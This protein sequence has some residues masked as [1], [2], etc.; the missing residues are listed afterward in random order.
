MYQPIYQSPGRWGF[1]GGQLG[2]GFARG[3]RGLKNIEEKLSGIGGMSAA[4]PSEKRELCWR[5]CAA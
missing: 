4:L 1:P 3:F 5:G 2:R